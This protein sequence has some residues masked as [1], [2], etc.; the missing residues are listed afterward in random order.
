M[1]LLTHTTESVA[2]G[3]SNPCLAPHTRVL[4]WRKGYVPACEVAVG[5][6]LVT[7]PDLSHQPTTTVREIRRFKSTRFIQIHGS[8]DVTEGHPFLTAGGSW[9]RAGDLATGDWLVG[10]HGPRR[11][12]SISRLHRAQTTVIDIVADAPFL[13]EG[14]VTMGKSVF[15]QLEESVNAVRRTA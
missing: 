1:D 4:V 11:L 9:V 7:P 8:I 6:L 3:E 5:S 15:L 10:P 14:F 13:V 12:E 2:P